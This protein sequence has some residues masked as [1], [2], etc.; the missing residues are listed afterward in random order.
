MM[1][2]HMSFSDLR[3]S[4]LVNGVEHVKISGDYRL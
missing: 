4:Y 3:Y 1:R 2:Y